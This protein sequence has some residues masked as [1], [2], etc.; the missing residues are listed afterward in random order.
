MLKKIGLLFA[1]LVSLSAFGKENKPNNTD[2]S[3]PSAPLVGCFK[4]KK[5][6][7]KSE[8]LIISES[9]GEYKLIISGNNKVN[10]KYTFYS[11]SKNIYK[12]LSLGGLS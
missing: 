3:K 4:E 6:E 8:H 2:I 11:G 10:E 1:I 12:G 9:N 7:S 5:N